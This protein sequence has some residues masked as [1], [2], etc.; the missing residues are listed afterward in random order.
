[1]YISA[2]KV[3]L[4]AMVNFSSTNY[5]LHVY[6]KALNANKLTTPVHDSITCCVNHVSTNNCPMLFLQIN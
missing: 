2:G 5:F 3:I 6:I 4:K 1:M